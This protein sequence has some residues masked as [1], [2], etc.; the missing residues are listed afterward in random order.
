MARTL[1]ES[2][3][4]YILDEASETYS[5]KDDLP[6]LYHQAARQ[7]NLAPNQHVE[8]SLKRA[9]GSCQAIVQEIGVL[10]NA[11]GDAHGKGRQGGQAQIRHAELAVNLAGAM[12]TFLIATWED[13]D[14]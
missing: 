9:L 13:R 10:R 5:D 6:G 4:K 7:L 3:C 1:L 2:T 8:Q 14:D 12:A 11:M